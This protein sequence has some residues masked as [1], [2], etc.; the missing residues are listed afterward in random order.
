MYSLG[1]ITLRYCWQAPAIG[2]FAL[3]N[4]LVHIIMY[5]Y[6]ALASL[7]PQIQKYLWWKR[8]ITQLQL[9]Q[10]FLFGIY[11]VFFFRNS[12]GY[13]TWMSWVCYPQPPLFF[14]MFLD[15]YLKS[16]KK[17]AKNNNRKK[18]DMNVSQT[19][20]N[21]NSIGIKSKSS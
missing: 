21:G 18:F 14:Y 10:F 19:D 2:L 7:G 12:S 16:Y 20:L 4:S 17:V 3:L 8:Y 15:F 13:P 9:G 1:W 11:S 5:S 6:Y